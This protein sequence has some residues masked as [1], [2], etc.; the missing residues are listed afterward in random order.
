MAVGIRL[1]I[2]GMWCIPFAPKGS[3]KLLLAQLSVSDLECERQRVHPIT[4]QVFIQTNPPFPNVLYGL[5]F[6]MDMWNKPSSSGKCSIR[7]VSLDVNTSSSLNWPTETSVQNSNACHQQTINHNPEPS[8]SDTSLNPQLHLKGQPYLTPLCHLPG[9]WAH[10]QGQITFPEKSCQAGSIWCKWILFT[11]RQLSTLETGSEML[12]RAF[13]FLHPQIVI[14]EAN[15]MEASREGKIRFK[16]DVFILYLT[17]EG[18][19]TV[20]NIRFRCFARLE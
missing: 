17:A 10:P 7:C 11:F 6:D 1:Y 2:R 9:K 20:Q 13:I 18:L 15:R 8:N 5:F 12:L 4:F 3:L 14:L 19:F 16:A